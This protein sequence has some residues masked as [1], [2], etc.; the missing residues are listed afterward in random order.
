[1]AKTI[2][3]YRGKRRGIDFSIEKLDEREPTPNNRI[4]FSIPEGGSIEIKGTGDFVNKIL[5]QLLEHPESLVLEKMMKGYD[6]LSER[7]QRR[8]RKQIKAGE[9][10]DPERDGWPAFLENT[11]GNS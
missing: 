4:F 1:M 9:F 11:D 2:K 5:R 6:D 7:D 8:F 10:A 3:R